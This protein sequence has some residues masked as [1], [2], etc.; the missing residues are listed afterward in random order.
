MAVVDYGAGRP[1]PP[2]MRDILRERELATNP[3]AARDAQQWKQDVV[4]LHEAMA[5]CRA[6]LLLLEHHNEPLLRVGLEITCN[7]QQRKCLYWDDNWYSVDTKKEYFR[8]LVREQLKR[9]MAAMGQDID[10]SELEKESK[11]TVDP[12]AFED[13]KQRAERAEAARDKALNQ[14]QNTEQRARELESTAQELNS[15]NREM[16][17]QLEELRGALE[18]ANANN[19]E[20]KKAL[21]EAQAKAEQ[22][23]T[24]KDPNAEALEQLKKKLADTER[25][26]K[27]E[28][29]QI[30]STSDQVLGEA[31]IRLQDGEEMIEFV[32]GWFQK[33]FNKQLVPGKMSPRPDFSSL[34]SAGG[35][36]GKGDGKPWTRRKPGVQKQ[37]EE[38]EKA[39]EEM[40]KKATATPPP[41]K[42]AAPKKAPPP[43]PPSNPGDS[44][45]LQMA[46]EQIAE[47]QGELEAERTKVGDLRASLKDLE[48]EIKK[49]QEQ[50]KLVQ[51]ELEVVT[52]KNKKLTDQLDDVK[53]ELNLAEAARAKAESTAERAKKEKVIVEVPVEKEPVKEQPRPVTPPPPPPPVEKTGPL[54]K[55]IEA[56]KQEIAAMQEQL[57]KAQ[58][59]LKNQANK[60]TQQLEEKDKEIA[61][62]KELLAKGKAGSQEWAAEKQ[63]L[64][65]KNFRLLK[66]IQQLKEQLQKVTELAE[67]KGLGKQLKNIMDES[68][69]TELL[70]SEEFNCFSRLYADALRRM[71]KYK[72]MNQRFEGGRAP[73]EDGSRFRRNNPKQG[74]QQWGATYMTGPGFHV[75]SVTDDST[76]FDTFAS[77]GK[78]PSLDFLSPPKSTS[79]TN[80]TFGGSRASSYGAD[81]FPRGNPPPVQEARSQ[82]HH[83]NIVNQELFFEPNSS[84]PFDTIPPYDP[85]GR[86]SSYIKEKQASSPPRDGRAGSVRRRALVPFGEGAGGGPSQPGSRSLSPEHAS[87]ADQPLG[88][89]WNPPGSPGARSGRPRSPGATPPG[90]ASASQRPGS[91]GRTRPALSS[92]QLAG[93]GLA[94]GPEQGGLP[95][96]SAGMRASNSL[97]TAARMATG[98]R[99]GPFGRTGDHSGMAGSSSLPDLRGGPGS[100]G[101]G[102]PDLSFGDGT[103]PAGGSGPRGQTLRRGSVSSQQARSSP[104]LHPDGGAPAL[105][106]SV[107]QSLGGGALSSQ[108]G[109]VRGN[110]RGGAGPAGQGHHSDASLGAGLG[111]ASALQAGPRGQKLPAS[112][113]VR[114][115][116]QLNARSGLAAPPDALS[117]HDLAAL[118]GGE[119]VAP[120]K[121][122][123]IATGV[124]S[125]FTETGSTMATKREESP[126]TGSLSDVRTRRSPPRRGDS[127]SPPPLGVIN[128]DF[129]SPNSTGNTVTRHR[130]P[131]GRPIRG[132]TVPKAAAEHVQAELDALADVANQRGRSPKAADGLA[133]VEGVER[134]LSPPGS[135]YAGLGPPSA[136]FD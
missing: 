16:A 119:S 91:G 55:E 86:L 18:D 2:F 13:M 25:S 59:A 92:V 85:S 83:V 24:A 64:E 39:M 87:P 30:R 128:L 129:S 109:T 52:Q 40:K 73:D 44:K 9:A 46:H 56:L 118:S 112:R 68:K 90:S 79:P 75:S 48:G 134:P 98:G 114:N 7:V 33:A 123:S 42:A 31:E 131:Q 22:A 60:F 41:A 29:A 27:D 34:D 127:G 82:Q 111:A 77:I 99:R 14:Q 23:K 113:M 65:D 35:K 17:R 54:K 105:Q 21:E 117:A 102:L 124:V 136:T 84:N 108:A 26:F 49:K 88:G 61:R 121:A 103:G 106:L 130:S 3:N 43:P 126:F 63:E 81:S 110:K 74:K 15:R 132:S 78:T 95:Q 125:P 19:E 67:K 37:L 133:V 8:V 116:A 20:S 94:A 66:A 93:Q 72:D 62:L 96:A 104:T 69:V 36:T 97:T 10:L 38:C 70:D 76:D 51:D 107:S 11:P 1:A 50:L 28:I 57:R 80:L 100:L 58:E 101:A 120:I 115:M 6:L 122:H 53:A 45:E 5:V 32:S 135:M 4:D 71:K 47:I 89:G 12:Q